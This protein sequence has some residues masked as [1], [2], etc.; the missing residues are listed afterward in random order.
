MFVYVQGCT[1]YVVRCTFALYLEYARADRTRVANHEN[2]LIVVQAGEGI[3]ACVCG[4]SERVMMFWC[5]FR[6]SRKTKIYSVRTDA[7]QK[8]TSSIEIA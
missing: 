7:D 4:V 8:T 3:S 1:F 6:F 5:G 2:P